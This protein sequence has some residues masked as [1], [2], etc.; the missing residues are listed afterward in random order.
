MKKKIIFT[1]LFG[2]ILY[3]CRQSLY[4]PA[5]PDATKQQALLA[6]RKLYVSHCSGCHNLH[7]PKEFTADRW[8]KELDEMAVKAKI[9]D[10]DKALIFQ[11]LTSQP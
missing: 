7:F 10:E 1:F 2:Y 6:G 4:M 9:N 5:S 11:Y 8:G 3:S